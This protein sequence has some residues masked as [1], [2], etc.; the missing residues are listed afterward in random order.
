VVLGAFWAPS[1][2]AGTVHEIRGVALGVDLPCLRAQS[3][4]ARW[5]GPLAL[6]AHQNGSRRR[7]EQPPQELRPWLAHV[8]RSQLSPKGPAAAAS[9][10]QPCSWGPYGILARPGSLAR[11]PRRRACLLRRGQCLGRREAAS[12]GAAPL[13]SLHISPACSS[14][15]GLQQQPRYHPQV[16]PEHLQAVLPREGR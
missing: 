7:V 11:G 15:P 14:Q 9:A 3:P 10:H 13:T 16:R 6:N 4:R 2:A 12:P 5:G 1:D 8:V